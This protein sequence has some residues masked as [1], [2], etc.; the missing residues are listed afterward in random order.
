VL[1]AYLSRV[2]IL[3]LCVVCS[4]RV[5]KFISYVSIDNQQDVVSSCFYF[6]L[7][8]V[9]STCFGCTL[10]PSSGVHKTV[11]T[12]T[13]ICHESWRHRNQIR[14]RMST[15][16]ATLHTNMAKNKFGCGQNEKWEILFLFHEFTSSLITNRFSKAHYTLTLVIVFV[17]W[18][19]SRLLSP[20]ADTI[21]SF[22]TLQKETFYVESCVA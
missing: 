18:S 1:N 12:S 11:V 16:G 5:T 2:I 7:L 6:V 20:K 8:Q 19:S 9:H 22:D 14:W 3:K 21:G 10:H 17:W 4:I 15:R 13:G